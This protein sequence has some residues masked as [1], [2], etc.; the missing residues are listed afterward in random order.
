MGVRFLS[1][2]RFLIRTTSQSKSIVINLTDSEN[3]KIGIA[4]QTHVPAE[5]NVY[6][7]ISYW[8]CPVADIIAHLL[9]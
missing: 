1:G 6:R 3:K 4:T 8:A 7:N 9:A 5:Y 2:A